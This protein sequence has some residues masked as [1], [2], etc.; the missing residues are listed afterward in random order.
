MC[1]T[2]GAAV[3]VRFVAAPTENPPL[4]FLMEPHSDKREVKFYTVVEGIWE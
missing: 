3:A 4:V 2:R 1:A